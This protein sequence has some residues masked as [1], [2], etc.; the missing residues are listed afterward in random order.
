MH[1]APDLLLGPPR[2]VPPQRGGFLFAGDPK[3]I[4]RRVDALRNRHVAQDAPAKGLGFLEVGLVK[5]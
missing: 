5:G 2:I 1:R 3:H 4:H